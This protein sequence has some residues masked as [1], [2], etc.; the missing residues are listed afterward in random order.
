MTSQQMKCLFYF[1]NT[2]GKTM[3]VILSKNNDTNGADALYTAGKFIQK[4]S[5]DI[6]QLDYPKNL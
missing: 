5:I 2:R 4:L 3:N 6:I 1:V